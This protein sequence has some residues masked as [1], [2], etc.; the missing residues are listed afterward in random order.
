MSLTT[1]TQ[2]QQKQK[3]KDTYIIKSLRK[4]TKNILKQIKVYLQ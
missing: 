2:T 4:V 3:H 1:Q